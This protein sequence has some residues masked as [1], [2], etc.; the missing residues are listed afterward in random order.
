MN[1][2]TKEIPLVKSSFER[3]PDVEYLAI[4][5]I[6]SFSLL[7]LPVFEVGTVEYQNRSMFTKKEMTQGLYHSFYLIVNLETVEYLEIELRGIS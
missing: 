3:L 7:N 1:N 6:F 4:Y 2:L 5:L